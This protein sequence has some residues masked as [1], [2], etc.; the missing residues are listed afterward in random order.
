MTF[1]TITEVAARENAT[2]PI[3]MTAKEMVEIARLRGR[4]GDDKVEY[5][6]NCAG[7]LYEDARAGRVAMTND[8]IEEYIELCWQQFGYDPTIRDR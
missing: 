7:D 3:A 5:T 8:E 6:R 2:D 4:E 1:V